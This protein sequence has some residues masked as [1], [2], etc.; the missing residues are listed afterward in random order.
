[1]LGH[2]TNPQRHIIKEILDD[3]TVLIN[4]DQDDDLLADNS[5]FPYNSTGGVLY[6]NI[7]SSIDVF[8]GNSTCGTSG[9]DPCS[10]IYDCTDYA[11]TIVVVEDSQE[12]P[13]E[14]FFYVGEPN[15]ASH[16]RD[17]KFNRGVWDYG[18]FNNGSWTGGIW[19]DGVFENGI[20][21]TQ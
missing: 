11:Q 19:I 15:I 17:G 18:Y 12:V 2:N 14:V 10:C 21:G 3:K 7:D 5:I 6:E 13:S 16:W 1:L 9:I 20:F 8:G 4:I